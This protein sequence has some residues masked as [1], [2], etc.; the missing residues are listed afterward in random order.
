MT[1]ESLT[2]ILEDVFANAVEVKSDVRELTTAMKAGFEAVD[3][4]FESMDQP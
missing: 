4:R 3:H 1:V 2:Q